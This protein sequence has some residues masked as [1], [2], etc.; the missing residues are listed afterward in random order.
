[1]LSLE[2]R[3]ECA[4]PVTLPPCLPVALLERGKRYHA[5]VHHDA[6]G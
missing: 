1:V 2:E 6:S 4:T 5:V 3:H